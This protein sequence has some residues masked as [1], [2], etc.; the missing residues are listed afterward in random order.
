MPIF[1]ALSP[2]A[3]SIALNTGPGPFPMEQTA[4]AYRG[5]AETMSI[6]ATCSEAHTAAL[7]AHWKGD[8]SNGA[9]AAYRRHSA[10]LRQQS[11]L[12]AQVA[13]RCD[14]Q[15]AAYMQARAIMPRPEAILANR[16]RA[17]TL[18]VGSTMAG[19]SAAAFAANEA[20]YMVMRALAAAAMAFYEAESQA[21]AAS[22]PPPIPPPA[23]TS[24]AG[25]GMVPPLMSLLPD[26]GPNSSG[27]GQGNQGGDFGNGGSQFDNNSGGQDGPSSSG[28]GG[29]GGGNGGG[30]GGGGGSSDSGGGGSSDAGNGGPNGGDT[31]PTD[32]GAGPND[33][34][35]GDPGLSDPV[36][37]PETLTDMGT[38]GPDT[39]GQGAM[40]GDPGFFGTTPGS[41]T[42]A[43]L[44]GGVGSAVALGM[45]R[46]GIG[47]MSGAAT[48]FR[49]PPSWSLRAPGATFGAPVAPPSGP[50]AA[51]NVPPRGAIAP[52]TRRRR[53]DNEEL[54]K[55][56]AVY[57]PGEPQEVPVLERP[58]AIGVI[59]Y[60]DDVETRDQELLGESARV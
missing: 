14:A 49:M 15:A 37:A 11:D 46:G 27:W 39:F 3:M 36:S 53:R 17:A 41:T 13:V 22:L 51:R 59:E 47:A 58:P 20:E 48:G 12:A 40:E 33:A 45:V 16:A 52:N 28:G 2:L 5:I 10:W 42:L 8:T 44:Q 29:D 23:I 54:R 6:A 19:A 60:S 25:G 50:P 7:A 32:G 57:T 31:L 35:P 9:L 43:G 24:A 38:P 55:T 34:M 21:N 4:R 1:A 30:D 56:A 18:A 26:T